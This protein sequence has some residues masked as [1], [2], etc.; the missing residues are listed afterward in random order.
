MR[1]VH[2]AFRTLPGGYGH[3]LQSAGRR[4]HDGPQFKRVRQYAGP[5]LGRMST[6]LRPQ[7]GSEMFH[8]WDSAHNSCDSNV[9]AGTAKGRPGAAKQSACT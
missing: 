7:A 6:I 4:V 9:L 5:D 3:L 1:K 8:E 2:E